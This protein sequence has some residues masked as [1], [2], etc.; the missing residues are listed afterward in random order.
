MLLSAIRNAAGTRSCPVGGLWVGGHHSLNAYLKGV[1]CS[2]REP[3]VRSGSGRCLRFLKPEWATLA[4]L[5][6]RGYVAPAD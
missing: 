1:T 4:P 5:F 3:A 6:G 2:G